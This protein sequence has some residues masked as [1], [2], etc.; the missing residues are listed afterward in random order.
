MPGLPSTPRPWSRPVPAAPPALI[1]P[2]PWGTE[3]NA[4]GLSSWRVRNS[5][6]ALS[7]PEH[8]R[9]RR[10]HE[11]DPAAGT[12][13]PRGFAS[14]PGLQVISRLVVPSRL[15]LRHCLCPPAPVGP[16]P[17]LCSFAGGQ[18]KLLLQPGQYG[19]PQPRPHPPHSHPCALASCL[20]LTTAPLC[21]WSYLSLPKSRTN[22]FR[23][24]RT[25]SAWMCA[26]GREPSELRGDWSSS[27]WAPDP[28]SSLA[29]AGPVT[30]APPGLPWLWRE[31]QQAGHGASHHLLLPRS[32]LS[33]GASSCLQPPPLAN[34]G[35]SGKNG[36]TRGSV[37]PWPKTITAPQP[38]HV[39]HPRLVTGK[40]F[41]SLVSTSL[42]SLGVQ[43]MFCSPFPG[44]L[45][46]PGS[47]HR[48]P[49]WLAATSWASYFRKKSTSWYRSSLLSILRAWGAEE[50]G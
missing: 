33:P 10:T 17:P 27:L 19:H 49:T 21:P 35:S 9:H 18:G 50:P 5:P 36:R 34:F 24:F 31:G 1:R 37:Q 42:P 11:H 38:C 8:H 14:L 47:P 3:S 12:C 6:V 46:L 32:R 40:H 48:G 45:A 30:P 20:A 23:I 44:P 15:S 28:P 25:S 16:S 7:G 39:H 4:P 22:A 13:L 29:S 2:S 43:V 26:D 41:S